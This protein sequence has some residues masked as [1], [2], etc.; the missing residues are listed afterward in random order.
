MRPD[1]LLD[2]LTTYVGNALG[3]EYVQEP[4]FDMEGTWAETSR[5]TPTFFVLFPGVD[6]H[7]VPV[8]EDG[9]GGIWHA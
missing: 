9:N 7:P 6:H 5:E 3:Q 4:P 1:R 8:E 2:A